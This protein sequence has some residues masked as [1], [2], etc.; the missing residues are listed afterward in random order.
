MWGGGQ[1]VEMTRDHKPTDKEEKLRIIK[2]GGN[3]YKQQVRGNRPQC[4]A[5]IRNF[6]VTRIAPGNLNVSRTLGDI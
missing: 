5:T 6:T 3:I 2:S 1:M 4:G